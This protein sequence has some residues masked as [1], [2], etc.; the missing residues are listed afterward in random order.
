MEIWGVWHAQSKQGNA[1]VTIALLKALRTMLRMPLSLWNHQHTSSACVCE[2]HQL[3]Q[4]LLSTELPVVYRFLSSGNVEKVAET[5]QLLTAAVTHSPAHCMLF[6]SNFNFTFPALPKLAYR[7]NKKYSA[8]KET[9]DVPSAE[10]NNEPA[11]GSS[12]T[13]ECFFRL[14]LAV[15]RTCPGAAGLN[16]ALR[17]PQ[18][19]PLAL[20]QL[21]Y[22][23][24]TSCHLM[25][26]TLAARITSPGTNLGLFIPSVRYNTLN[27]W[28]IYTL[29]H[30]WLEVLSAGACALFHLFGCKRKMLGSV[31]QFHW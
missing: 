22:V 1:K 6:L 23:D 19:L 13:Y 29:P 7:P 30:T 10:G 28:D 24:T 12:N 2:L 27:V 11:A 18:L 21:T 20:Q 26:E 14:A 15:L 3:A 31:A 4:F 25:C 16:K 9:S 17:A 8:Q 5:L